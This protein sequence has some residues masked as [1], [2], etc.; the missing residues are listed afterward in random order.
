MRDGGR[1]WVAVND[2]ICRVP[3]VHRRQAPPKTSR[4]PWTHWPNGRPTRARVEGGRCWR[5]RQSMETK[6]LAGEC[7]DMHEGFGKVSWVTSQVRGLKLLS[8]GTWCLL[9]HE[10]SLIDLRFYRYESG[11][12]E[13]LLHRDRRFRGWPVNSPVS[14]KQAQQTTKATKIESGICAP[15]K[16]DDHTPLHPQLK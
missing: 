6:G 11:I 1:G 15:P 14:N 5:P 9:R 7:H 10:Y 2:P 8:F 13:R 16:G 4:Q 3:I 12:R